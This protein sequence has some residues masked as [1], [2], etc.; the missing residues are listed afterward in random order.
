MGYKAIFNDYTWNSKYMFNVYL[1]IMTWLIATENMCH[2][3]PRICSVS[4]ITI[5][6]FSHSSPITG[7]V[8]KSNTTGATCGA[9]TAYHSGHESSLPAF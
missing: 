5:R 7:F 8:N 9:G 1:A 3:W 6:Y 4:L 2:N